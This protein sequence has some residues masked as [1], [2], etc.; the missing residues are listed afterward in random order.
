MVE[1]I[2]R[3]ALNLEEYRNKKDLKEHKLRKNVK[4][5]FKSLVMEE[6]LPA[7]GVI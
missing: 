6:G 3:F 1:R 7:S 4:S 2:R 5:L